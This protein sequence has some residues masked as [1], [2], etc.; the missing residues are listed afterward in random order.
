MEIDQIKK[1]D[2]VS[3]VQSADVYLASEGQQGTV[4]FVEQRSDGTYVHIVGLGAKP[5]LR[6][7]F[8]WQ[9]K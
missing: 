4:E 7:R 8:K 3:V 2:I 6:R 5:G 9:G 1:G